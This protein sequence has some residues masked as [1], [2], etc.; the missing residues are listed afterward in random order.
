MTKWLQ[1]S[2]SP[3]SYPPGPLA[4]TL[5]EK[6]LTIPSPSLVTAPEDH[7]CANGN[8]SL[9][10][11]APGVD[12][13][14]S[15][16]PPPTTEI[17][18]K[19]KVV[20]SGGPRDFWNNLNTVRGVATM[21]DSNGTKLAAQKLVFILCIVAAITSTIYVSSHSIPPPV[22]DGLRKNMAAI[23]SAIEEE[24]AIFRYAIVRVLV[25]MTVISPVD[26]AIPWNGARV[27]S[28]WTS[29]GVGESHLWLYKTVLG[30]TVVPPEA[31]LDPHLPHWSFL[32][33]SGHIAFELH[34]N[35]TITTVIIQSDFP[36]S[37]PHSVRIWTFVQK[38]KQLSCRLQPLNT[39]SFPHRLENRDLSPL[40]LGDVFSQ[41]SSTPGE[42]S[43][44]IPRG[45][46]G[47]IPIGMVMLEFLSNRGSDITRIGLIRV[48]G[49]PS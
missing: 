38:P 17:K 27:V 25:W 8:G 12:S 33:Q 14:L 49:I 20:G 2:A 36:D 24:A 35:A 30:L 3:H 10:S 42:Y 28:G 43:Y 34:R 29:P 26:C 40:L 15:V 18:A 9:L 45:C 11:A 6:P 39:P 22:F 21:I 7:Q 16:L 48:L 23:L 41:A 13:V 44:H 4:D 32:G 19:K 46:Y 1:A 37:V 5:D 47:H 31:A